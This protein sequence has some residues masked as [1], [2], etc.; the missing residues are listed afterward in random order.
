MKVRSQIAELGYR[1]LPDDYNALLF[2]TEGPAVSRLVKGQVQNLFDRF[3]LTLEPQE[4]K[5]LDFPDLRILGGKQPVDYLADVLEPVQAIKDGLLAFG[6]FQQPKPPSIR[7]VRTN[8]NPGWTRFSHDGSI[9]ISDG[10][11][12]E[13]AI[14]DVE[15]YVK[16]RN[17]PV[18]ASALTKEAYYLWL[19]PAL[20]STQTF[21]PLLIDLGSKLRTVV[22]FNTLFD[23]NKTQQ[24]YAFFDRQVN[25][26]DLMSMH[27]VCN[28]ASREQKAVL[29]KPQLTFGT[30]WKQHTTLENSLVNAYNLH[31][32]HMEPLGQED[33][34]LRNLFKVGNLETFRANLLDLIRYCLLD[35]F[36]TKSL[37]EELLPKYFLHN[38]HLVTLSGHIHLANTLLPVVDNW[39]TWV[40][41]VEG[42]YR[43]LIL[44]LNQNLTQLA[45]EL[46]KEGDTDFWSAQLDWTPA[47]SG[48]SKGLPAWYRK[49]VINKKK[50]NPI[51][52]QTAIAPLLLK[53]TWAGNPMFYHP[54]LK[55]CYTLPE[56]T[57]GCIRYAWK[58]QDLYLK[59][60]PHAKGENFNCGSPLGKDY[61]SF[62]ATEIMSSPNPRTLEF[63][64]QAKSLAYWKS[65]NKRVKE[66]YTVK[67]D[68]GCQ[69]IKPYLL[70]H[71]TITR[72][73]V[74]S[75]WLTCSDI[76][77]DVVG[78]EL[79]S[80]IQA[81]PGYKLVGAD[82]D[83]QELNYGAALSDSFFGLHG[84][85]PMGL[86]QM[87]G[88]KDKKTDGH[89][90]LA[91]DVGTDRQLAKTLNFLMLFFGGMAGL[92]E[93]IKANRLDLPDE[94][95]KT[96]ARKA[97]S[98]RRGV[99]DRQ[100]GLYKGG[101]DS[102][103]YNYMMKNAETLHNRTA[104]SKSA[105][106]RCLWKDVVGK[107]FMPSRCNRVIQSGGVDILHIFVTLLNHFIQRYGIQGC[108]IISIHDEVWS[109]VIESQVD[110]MAQIFQ[111]CHLLTWA[112]VYQSLGFESIPFD[113]CFFSSINVDYCIRKEVDNPTQW[114]DGEPHYLGLKTPSNPDDSTPVGYL[115]KPKDI[116]FT[117]S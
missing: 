36:Y 6:K 90:L 23:A 100:T 18:M 76:K 13:M 116:V 68:I 75:T 35:S 114:I 93:A 5:E 103:A 17:Y 64:K 83:A 65:M 37:M 86:T 34:Q 80:R 91:K 106:S 15:T 38:P 102:Q 11:L 57:E 9:Q 104:F 22:N 111:L 50:D 78:S 25:W 19:H 21:E 33:K 51:S 60:I 45:H 27:I 41:Q 59:K 95:A 99:K 40:N 24:A 48:K 112:L 46:A 97:L 94:E 79:K 84:S 4:N 56:E 8:L 30:M 81:P 92:F 20:L 87:L 12:E 16:F 69:S 26:I 54:K 14:F 77:P 42:T 71:G 52:T 107:E 53:M 43:R 73:A 96:I 101:T 66:F 108:F 2:G 110:L 113:R 29:A 58:N 89:S 49:H 74:E 67:S 7:N 31:C 1:F 10:I 63:M 72:R 88:D 98:L 117:L 105:I 47:K 61:I 55:W 3:G 82:F 115:I 32:S 39:D 70:P 109:M 85:T 62:S 28:G 44:G